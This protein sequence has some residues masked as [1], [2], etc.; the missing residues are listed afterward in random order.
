MSSVQLLRQRNEVRTAMDQKQSLEL[1]QTMLHS[2]LSSITYIRGLFPLKSYDQRVYEMRDRMLP[3][4]DF[5][6]GRMPDDLN[7]AIAPHTTIRVLRRGRSR[8]VDTFLDW[9]VS[10][11][12]LQIQMT[13]I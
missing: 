3:Y 8:R 9:L 7:D 10:N 2:A 13:S 11:A 4:D 5:A 12:S 1:V 6:E